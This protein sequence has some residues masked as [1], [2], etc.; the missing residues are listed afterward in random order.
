[1]ASIVEVAKSAGV[2]T[3]T[4]SNVLNSRP[5]NAE[6]LQ[7]VRRAMEEL[8]YEPRRVRSGRSRSTDLKSV[9]L[10]ILGESIK[11][12][13]RHP[14]YFN[15]IHGIER[16]CDEHGLPFKLRALPAR[17]D[18]QRFAAQKGEGLVLFRD[19]VDGLPLQAL[20]GVPL[21]KAFNAPVAG[22][23]HVTYNDHTVG[24]IAADWL[25]KQNVKRVGVISNPGWARSTALVAALERHGCS[26]RSLDA[27]RYM[28][29]PR[30]AGAL[31]SDINDRLLGEDL[32]DLMRNDEPVD[33]LFLYS[34]ELAAHAYPLL[35]GMGIRPQRDVHV[36]SCNCDKPYLATLRPRPATID[37]HVEDVGHAA[38]RLLLDR[39]AKPESPVRSLLIE[40]TVVS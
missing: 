33:G 11:A 7:R 9:S 3:G 21:V 2:S 36:I 24:V 18:R 22:F 20:S 28:Q 19:H 14:V 32:A 6:T 8:G 38:V 39:A 13:L 5:V 4:V 10:L 31:H 15:L 37:I 25:L 34:D 30:V 29:A 40:P 16:D 12:V 26:I 17:E 1:M 27:T 23:D 35:Y